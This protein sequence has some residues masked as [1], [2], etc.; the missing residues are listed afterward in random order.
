MIR[1]QALDLSRTDIR[2]DVLEVLPVRRHS[3][4]LALHVICLPIVEKINAPVLGADVVLRFADGSPDPVEKLQNLRFVIGQGEGARHLAFRLVE[5][6]HV[7]P[8]RDDAVTDFRARELHFVELDSLANY[9]RGRRTAGLPEALEPPAAAP[10]FVSE[11]LVGR[12]ALP[13]KIDAAVLFALEREAVHSQQRA[14]ATGVSGAGAHPAIVEI[15]RRPFGQLE[16]AGPAVVASDGFRPAVCA[17]AANPARRILQDEIDI[18][19]AVDGGQCSVPRP[20][21]FATGAI[22]VAHGARE[23]E[24][25]PR[26]PRRVLRRL[27]LTSPSCS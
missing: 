21:S 6:I 13:V 23:G 17:Q 1:S 20:K 8:P 24:M 26:R 9:G 2:N 19:S 11:N 12:I 14:G 7:A 18:A 5:R 10:L 16:V 27:D 22:E 25:L 15:R 4:N 3:E